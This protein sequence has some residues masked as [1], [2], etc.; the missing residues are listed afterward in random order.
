MHA[1]R[2][3]VLWATP[4]TISTA[5]DRMMRERGDHTVLTEP[6]SRWY[7]FGADRP[8][9][10]FTEVLDDS[11]PDAIRTEIHDAVQ[12]GPVFVKEMAYHLG[13]HL[14]ADELRGVTSSFLIR[15]PARA[16][17]SIA[18]VWP[19]VTWEECGYES[20][21]RAYE[22]ACDAHAASNMP[23]PVVLD[24]REVRA[25]PAALIE[26]WCE[27]VGIEF[28]PESLTWDAGEPE[29]ADEQWELWS[30]WFEGAVDSTGFE[31]P[32]PGAPPDVAN[33]R[34]VALIE[35]AQPIYEH[36]RARRLLA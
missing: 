33:P 14:D 1:A 35:R 28:L 6:W 12:Q 32:A 13:Q 16:I 25:R 7:Y 30:D 10:R 18:H 31:P 3:L 21:L 20:L 23:A 27:A 9:P 29:D 5:F 26:A 22:L 8:S 34:L 11:S 4:R 2:P 15:D 19:D 24:G 36:L 17:P